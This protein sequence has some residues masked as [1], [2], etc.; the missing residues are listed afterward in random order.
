MHN[1][2]SALETLPLDLLSHEHIEVVLTLQQH[3]FNMEFGLDTAMVI[4][5]GTDRAF[6][7]LYFIPLM[8]VGT[9]GNIWLICSVARILSKQWFPVNLLFRQISLYILTLSIVDLSVSCTQNYDSIGT[10]IEGDLV[11]PN[12]AFLH[13]LGPLALWH[14]RL[15]TVLCG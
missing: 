11:N 2:S 7:L 15:Q 14:N 12:A 9:L 3:L 4:R 6:V 10:P 8:M 13:P 1:V 5:D